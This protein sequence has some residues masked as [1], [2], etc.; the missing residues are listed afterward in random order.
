MRIQTIGVILCIFTVLSA[1]AADLSL[2]GQSNRTFENQTYDKLI[3]SNCSE[4]TI[5]GCSFSASDGNVVNISSNCS[6]ITLDS[7]DID[8]LSAAC[9]GINMGGSF[10]TVRKCKI[11]HI[12]DDGIQ[13]TGGGDHWTFDENEI[14]HLLGCGT[15]GGCGPCYNGHS[16]GF[17]MGGVDTV[18]LRRNLVYDVR[19]T[20]ALF[21]NNWSG[22]AT[23]HNLVLENNIFYTPECGVVMYAFY[24]DGLTMVNNTIW[25]SDW[26]GLA[27]GP[28]ASRITAYNNIFQNVDYNFLKGSYNASDHKYDYNLVGTT[29]R[30][31][32]LQANDV[33]D[34]D[35]KFRRI[36]IATDNTSAHVYRDVTAADFELMEGS[37]AIGQGMAGSL[38]PAV[39]F[40]GNP[41]SAPH[42]LGAIAYR[43]IAIVRMPAPVSTYGPAVF[44]VYNI[45]GQLVLRFKGKY[46]GP[47]SLYRFNR[48]MATLRSGIYLCRITAGS[49]NVSVKRAVMR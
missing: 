39:D 11:H 13:C 10:I 31:L 12:A 20:A 26:L 24:V 15:D 45:R 43:S 33:L 4:I 16:D 29:G 25:K 42:D 9:T 40:Y 19:S 7:C 8:G 38:V 48:K 34:P 44:S 30:G 32:P 6:R 23:I 3:L 27:V 1:W 46:D 22:G 41:R 47:G 21:M 35:P 2:S 49:V 5:R 37:P 28:D 18:V 14:C 17:E 36:P